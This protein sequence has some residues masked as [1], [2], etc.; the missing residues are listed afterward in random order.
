M[1]AFLRS[2]D[3]RLAQLEDLLIMAMVAMIASL[4]GLGVVLRYVFNNPL[5]WSEE[6]VVT[7]FVW[8]VMLGVPSALRSRM[9]IRIDVMILRLSHTARRIVGGV[10]CLAGLVIMCAAV[11]AGYAHTVGV[12][13]SQTPMLGFSMGWIFLAMPVGF[14]LTLFHGSMM[15]M[16]EGPERVFQNATETVIDSAPV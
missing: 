13:S 2:L 14:A 12:W 9:H 16:E 6:F 5:T 4:L 10:A 7:L 15:L 3:K 1:L 8:S 11:Y